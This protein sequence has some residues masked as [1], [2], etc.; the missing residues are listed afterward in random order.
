MS[1]PETGRGQASTPFDLDECQGLP[2]KKTLTFEENLKKGF[3]QE[4]R[5]LDLL[6]LAGFDCYGIKP[7]ELREG[8]VMARDQKDCIILRGRTEVPIEVKSH[9]KRFL[10][11][12]DFEQSTGQSFVTLDDLEPWTKK[13]PK[14]FA[15]VT[16]SEKATWKELLE[17]KGLIVAVRDLCVG[18]EY[19]K[20]IWGV[21][22]VVRVPLSCCIDWK[23]FIRHL[24]NNWATSPAK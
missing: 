16:I 9:S 17:G 8:V 15:V 12:D 2:K 14:P 4:G 23:D 7:D 20:T 24:N 18:C 10:G 5:V 3:A 22:K 13:D 11:V 21:K 19:P 6:T 1:P